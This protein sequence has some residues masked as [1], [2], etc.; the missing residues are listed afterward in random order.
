MYQG[1]IQTGIEA[2]V[3]GLQL[4]DLQWSMRSGIL[5][6]RGYTYR[7]IQ[8]L[9]AIEMVLSSP[10]PELISKILE[11]ELVAGKPVRLCT[12]KELP[13]IDIHV[14]DLHTEQEPCHTF[15]MG[16]IADAPVVSVC[17]DH[18]LVQ[19]AFMSFDLEQGS[20]HTCQN[21]D[22]KWNP[23]GLKPIKDFSQRVAPGEPCPS[24]ECPACG[25]LCQPTGSMY[26][27]P[28]PAAKE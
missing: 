28:A 23:R 2:V 26:D 3:S 21:C 17:P 1:E 18:P 14:K 8:P 10:D 25:A 22:R 16:M 19:S 24:G 20:I 4:T 12:L 13:R 7:T 15:V 6:M 11:L 9:G 27:P 5:V